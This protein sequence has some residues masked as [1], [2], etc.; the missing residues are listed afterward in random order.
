MNTYRERGRREERGQVGVK[1]VMMRFVKHFFKTKEMGTKLR[2]KIS[3]AQRIRSVQ[4]LVLFLHILFYF[5]IIF[6]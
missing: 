3:S 4:H 5:W 6:L 1:S 2:V